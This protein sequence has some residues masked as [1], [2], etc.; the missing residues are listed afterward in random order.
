MPRA[1]LHPEL[2]AEILEF[3]CGPR[4]KYTHTLKSCSRVNREFRHLSQTLLFESYTI[5]LRSE[6]GEDSRSVHA[7]N[8]GFGPP[9]TNYIK[10]LTFWVDDNVETTK[11]SLPILTEL[12]QN[13]LSLRRLRLVARSQW[14]EENSPALS[15]ALFEKLHLLVQG[16]TFDLEW[17]GTPKNGEVERVNTLLGAARRLDYL[18]ISSV[19]IT[20]LLAPFRPPLSPNHLH[21]SSGYAEDAGLLSS[22]SQLDLSNC[23]SLSLS[24]VKWSFPVTAA[25]LGSLTDT[26]RDFH[27]KPISSTQWLSSSIIC[28]FKVLQNFSFSINVSTSNGLLWMLEAI[29]YFKNMP[30]L[31]S[32]RIDLGEL[33]TARVD[34]KWHVE[35]AVIRALLDLGSAFQL[36]SGYKI[37]VCMDNTCIRIQDGSSWEHM[38]KVEDDL[39]DCLNGSRDSND[40]QI[41]FRSF[42]I[43]QGQK[44]IKWSRR[45][46]FHF[47]PLCM[48][49][50]STADCGC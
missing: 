22:Q 29:P 23:I 3:L 34:S 46:A 33:P 48:L 21:L 43:D 30:V 31:S 15:E 18:H 45:P 14:G 19:S 7:L 37:T 25:F 24:S 41:R 32:I 11:K 6:W 16:R 27:Y 4:L 50:G 28:S 40:I 2:Y 5:D 49:T 8:E 44:P 12:V 13:V 1:T 10:V 38:R 26:L 35:P 9:M 20:K 47:H 39:R 36:L 17:S 42:N